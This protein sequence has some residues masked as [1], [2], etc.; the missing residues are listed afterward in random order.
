MSM[1]TQRRRHGGSRLAVLC[2]LLA[3]GWPQPAGAGAPPRRPNVLFILADDL[4]WADAGYSGSDFYETPNIDRLAREGAV[5]TTAY[6]CPN[7]APT[8]AAILSGQYPPRTRVYNVGSLNRGNGKPPLVGPPQHQD[9][10]AAVTTIAETLKKAGYV[11]AHFGKYHV[12]GHEG[13]RATL[14]ESQGF[15]FNFGGG[16]AGSPGS[17]WAVKSRSGAWQ[18]GRRIGPELDPYAAP[19][20]AAYLARCRFWAEP[21]RRLPAS[22]AGTK[23]HVGD[24]L[25]DAAI[26]FIESQRKSGRPWYVQF[27]QY[28]VHSPLQP[29]PDLRAKYQAKRL[30]RPSRIGQTNVNYAAMVE[31]LDQSVGRLLAYLTDPDGNGDCSDSLAKNTLVIFYSDNGGPRGSTSNFPLRGYKGM[32][33]EGGVRVPLIFWMPGRAPHRTHSAPV[34][35]V[36]F[37]KTL[38]DLAGAPLP[39]PQEQPLDGVSLAPLVFGQTDRLP[40]RA[41]YWHFPGYLDN[42]AAPCS[43][44]IRKAGDKRYKLIYYYETASWSLFNLTDDPS[45]TTDLAAT[46]ATRSAHRAVAAGLVADL[47]AWLDKVGAIYPTVRATGEKVGPPQFDTASFR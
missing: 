34:I 17:Y 15:D 38:A 26:A 28:L 19:Y 21:N 27:H 36:D 43:T 42:R 33:Y 2:L 24:A 5:F 3:A 35:M 6:T 30:A 18:F 46:P 25:T 45:E 22:L 1:N 8:R 20:D 41:L 7:C 29:R 12:G 40:E 14:P 47:R 11:T 4:G 37:Y 9:A 13:G 10:P 31:Q 39:N 44:I 32:F 16:P 23:K